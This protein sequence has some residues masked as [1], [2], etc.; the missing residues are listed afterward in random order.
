[1]ASKAFDELYK[2]SVVLRINSRLTEDEQRRVLDLA[3]GKFSDKNRVNADKNI[4]AAL[5]D[6]LTLTMPQEA[7]TKLRKASSAQKDEFFKQM[8][9]SQ[10]LKMGGAATI[11]IEGIPV[12]F[13][14]SLD[15]SRDKQSVEKQLHELAQQVEGD[16]PIV[17]GINFDETGSIK[18]IINSS[19]YSKIEQYAKTIEMRSTLSYPLSPAK[20]GLEILLQKEQVWGCRGKQSEETNPE[21]V[22]HFEGLEPVTRINRHDASSLG[23]IKQPDED[24]LKKAVLDILKIKARPF[25]LSHRLSDFIALKADSA[26]TVESLLSASIA[27]SGVANSSFHLGGDKWEADPHHC[28]FV[29]G[30]RPFFPSK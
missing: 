30:A 22:Y 25:D 12:N 17:N 5:T 28:S 10:S 27:L 7:L 19:E 20:A 15:W 21:V 1:M 26:K 3:F 16:V 9:D 6:T 23:V 29:I 14:G 18:S 13:S 8:S 4:A 11:P 24:F 2:K